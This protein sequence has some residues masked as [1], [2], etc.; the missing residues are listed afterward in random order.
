MAYRA[1]QT[2][3]Q[4]FRQPEKLAALGYTT[5]Q[6]FWISFAINQCTIAKPEFLRELLDDYGGTPAEFRVMGAVM[7]FQDFANDFDCPV[8]SHMNPKDKCTIW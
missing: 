2:W 4:D 5:N 1:Y 7:N 6:M 3:A 8:G